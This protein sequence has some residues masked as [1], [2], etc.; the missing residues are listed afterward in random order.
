MMTTRIAGITAAFIVVVGFADIAEA[1]TT[2]ATLPTITTA[3]PA[4]NVT[5]EAP[6]VH[7]TASRPLAL[8]PLYGSFIGLQALDFDSTLRGIRSGTYEANPMMGPIANSPAMLLAFK[9]GTAAAV[10]NVCEQLRKEH[11]GTA[12]VLLM[13]G[14]NSAYATVVAHNYAVIRQQR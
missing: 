7:K 6:P 9:A 11:H 1:Q 3:A 13:I 8:A 5:A 10:I 12:A 2:T 4:A 14:I